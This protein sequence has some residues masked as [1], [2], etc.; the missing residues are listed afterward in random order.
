MQIHFQYTL[1]IKKEHLNP[2]AKEK[3]T[4]KI[5]CNSYLTNHFFGVSM[6]SICERKNAMFIFV[7]EL[8]KDTDSMHPDMYGNTLLCSFTK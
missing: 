5:N 6:Y 3:H 8:N 1:I 7:T 4:L 2:S